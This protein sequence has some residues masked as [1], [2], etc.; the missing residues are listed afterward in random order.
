MLL[1]NKVISQCPRSILKQIRGL[2]L[3]RLPPPLL[4]PTC[5]FLR[6]LYTFKTFDPF[7]RSSSRILTASKVKERCPPPSLSLLANSLEIARITFPRG[8]TDTQPLDA[9]PRFS[10]FF[11]RINLA[12]FRGPIYS[13]RAQT[14]FND[15]STSLSRV[16]TFSTIFS[17]T[18]KELKLK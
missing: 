8:C 11:S 18:R 14:F 2:T 1:A 17:R 13:F 16:E 5:L 7:F 12:V 3:T 15:Y 9:F 4:L 6:A 10:P